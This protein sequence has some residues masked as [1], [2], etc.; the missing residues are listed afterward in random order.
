MRLKSEEQTTNFKE[1]AER[2]LAIRPAPGY[3]QAPERVERLKEAR[4]RS[5]WK[6][7]RKA[8]LRDKAIR[9]P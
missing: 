4:N 2:F 3:I 6:R 5:E 7:K 8:D 1:L 9:E